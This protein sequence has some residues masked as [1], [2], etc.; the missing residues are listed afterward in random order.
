MRPDKEYQNLQTR[1]AGSA[2]FASRAPP[3]STSPSVI[4]HAD[5]RTGA[6]DGSVGEASFNRCAPIARAA[7]DRAYMVVER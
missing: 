4:Q 1:R 2:N 5:D 3:C 6:E 7:M